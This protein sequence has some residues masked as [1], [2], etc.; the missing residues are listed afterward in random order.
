MRALKFDATVRKDNL[1]TRVNLGKVTPAPPRA[2]PDELVTH[3]D[4]VDELKPANV[5]EALLDL[6]SRNIPGCN[7]YHCY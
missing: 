2:V 3:D 7:I 6:L 4:I 1:I 5:P